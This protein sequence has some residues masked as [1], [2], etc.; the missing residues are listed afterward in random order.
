MGDRRAFQ[1]GSDE[2]FEMLEDMTDV[3]STEVVGK[4]LPE[5]LF[6]VF[7]ETL[8]PCPSEETGLFEEFPTWPLG[9]EEVRR[10]CI[11]PVRREHSMSRGAY[12]KGLPQ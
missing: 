6:H 8:M 1:D 5:P 10:R 2:Y 9:T 11:G 3:I 12:R 7:S 4:G